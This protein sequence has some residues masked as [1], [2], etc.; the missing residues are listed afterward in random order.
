MYMILVMMH[1]IK[2]VFGSNKTK[3]PKQDN[4]IG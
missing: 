4:Q 1:L 2:Q 3:V